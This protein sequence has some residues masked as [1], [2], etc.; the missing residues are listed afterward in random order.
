MFF[1]SCAYYYVVV[2]CL[3]LLFLLLFVFLFLVF[4]CFV[5]CVFVSLFPS[6]LAMMS[7]DG[8][9]LVPGSIWFGSVFLVT[10]AEFVLDQLM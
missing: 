5:F 2:V 7:F 6:F 4:F 9:L 10:A 1:L 8:Y 3:F